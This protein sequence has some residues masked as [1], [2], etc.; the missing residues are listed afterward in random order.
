MLYG[1]IL[2]VQ[3]QSEIMS[4]NVRVVVSLEGLRMWPAGMRRFWG[5]RSN[6]CLDLGNGY[7]A[8]Y[9]CTN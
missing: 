2:L 1:S 9:T 8:V 5:A 3:Q 4:G 6:L 7:M